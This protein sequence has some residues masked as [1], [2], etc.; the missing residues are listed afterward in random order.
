MRRGLDG[1]VVLSG[2]SID[3]RKLARSQG[4][5]DFNEKRKGLASKRGLIP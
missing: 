4:R 1:S 5:I 3:A 2:P